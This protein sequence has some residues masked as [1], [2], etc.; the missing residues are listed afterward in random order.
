M[1][2]MVEHALD[3]IDEQMQ[4]KHERSIEFGAAIALVQL[5]GLGRAMAAAHC[6]DRG[7]AAAATGG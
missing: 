7:Q 2:A 1:D 4:Y 5:Y 3:M 6:L